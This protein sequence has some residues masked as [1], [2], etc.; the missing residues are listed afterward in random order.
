MTE[1][2]PTF[3]REYFRIFMGLV[4]FL[5]GCLL[6]S[7]AIEFKGIAL[8]LPAILI[9]VGGI[10]AGIGGGVGALLGMLMVFSGGSLLLHAIGLID[11]PYIVA[12][13]GWIMLLLGGIQ[14]AYFSYKIWKKWKTNDPGDSGVDDLDKVDY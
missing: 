5:G 12:F 4:I 11:F 3:I 8:T 13:F 1:Q 6:V 10:L 9:L 14:I 7:H 2:R